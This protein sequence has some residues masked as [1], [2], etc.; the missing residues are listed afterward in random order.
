MSVWKVKSAFKIPQPHFQGFLRM[1][2]S[3][4]GLSAE[5]VDTLLALA[6]Q[7]ALGIDS[8]LISTMINWTCDGFAYRLKLT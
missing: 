7:V 6:Y 1:I 4:S 2:C 8:A 5:P 3:E